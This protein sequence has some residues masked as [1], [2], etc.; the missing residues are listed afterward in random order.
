MVV[1]ATRSI[2]HPTL[3]YIKDAPDLAHTETES[4]QSLLS[5]SKAQG[6]TQVHLESKKFGYLLRV[7]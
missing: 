4:M 5:T 2:V 7:L 3:A 6:N 1:A